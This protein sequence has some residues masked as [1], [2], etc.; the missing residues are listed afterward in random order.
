MP[1]R[2]FDLI[3]CRYVAFTYFAVPLQRKVLV[4]MLERLRQEGYLVIGTHEQL[5]GDVPELVSLAGAPQI[6]QKRAL[7]KGLSLVTDLAVRVSTH[8]LLNSARLQLIEIKIP[9]RHHDILFPHR[10]PAMPTFIM[11]TRLNP[12]AVRSPRGLEQ[13]ERDAMKRI[14]E[15]CPDVEWLSSYAVLGPCDYLDVFIANDIETAARV[16]AL[17][18]H[19]RSRPDRNLDGDRVGPVQGNRPYAAGTSLITVSLCCGRHAGRSRTPEL[20][21]MVVGALGSERNRCA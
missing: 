15:E 14:R 13:L 7:P 9:V 2:L 3:L 19:V 16:S 12:D 21:G 8:R 5:P 10:R 6:F 1:P 18:P 17:D 4:R 20:K 11:L